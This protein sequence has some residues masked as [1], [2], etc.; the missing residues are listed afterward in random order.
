L[1]TEKTNIKVVTIEQKS[2]CC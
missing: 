1:K 2:G